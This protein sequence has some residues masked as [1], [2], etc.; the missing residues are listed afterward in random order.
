L[1]IAPSDLRQHVNQDQPAGF[2][3]KKNLLVTG[4]KLKWRF[5]AGSV[6]AVEL[7]VQSSQ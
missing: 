3:P 1:E 5:P 2:A 6:T 4:E 7:E